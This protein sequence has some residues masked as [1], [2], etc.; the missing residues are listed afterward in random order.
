MFNFPSLSVESSGITKSYPHGI[1]FNLD[2]TSRVI[3]FYAY[4]SLKKP[5]FQEVDH[6]HLA[7]RMH[8]TD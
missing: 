1:N 5:N 8:G 4:C 6:F 7:P 3:T 2:G